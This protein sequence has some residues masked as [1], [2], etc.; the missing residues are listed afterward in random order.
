MKCKILLTMMILAVLSFPG[1]T[2]RGNGGSL[3]AEVSGGQEREREQ[4]QGNL[5]Y[6]PYQDDEFS[7]WMHDLRRAESLFFGSLPL[8]YG[9]A[10]LSFTLFSESDGLL[11]TQD[12][13]NRLSAAAM[14]SAAVAVTDYIIG[15]IGN[16]SK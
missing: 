3:F 8:T 14:L 1:V 13:I 5:S 7:L 10:S 9:I 15:I 2:E 12:Y 4:E 16:E 11:T 6:S